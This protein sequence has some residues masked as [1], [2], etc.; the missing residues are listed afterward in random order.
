MRQ[1]NQRLLSILSAVLDGVL[2]LLSYCLAT[3]LWLD[4]LKSDAG[5]LA[6]LRGG[7]PRMLMYAAIY[8]VFVVLVMSLLGLYSTSRVRRLRREIPRIWGANLLGLLAGMAVLYLLRA[9]SFSRGVLVLFYLFSA[10]LLSIKCYG[11]R[12][13]LAEARKRGYNQRHVLVLGSGQLAAH[14]MQD[15]SDNPGLGLH[16]LGWL[17]R[18]DESRPG[19]LAP[20]QGLDALLQRKDVDEVVAALEPE[21]L[22]SIRSVINACEKSGTKVSVV[23]FYSDLIPQSAAIETVGST[24]IINLRANPLDNLGL[25]ML[26]RGF[27]VLASLLLLILLSPLLAVLAIGVKLSGPGPVLFRQERVGRNKHLFTMFKFR[28]MVPNDSENKAWSTAEDQR[29]TG[30]GAFMR[31]FSLDELP[32][33]LNVLRGDMSLVGPRPEIPFYVERFK[34][35]VPLYMVK[36]QVRPGMTGWAQVNGWRGDTDIA[37]RIRYD[38]WYIENWSIRLDLRIL[39]RTAFGGFVNRQE[40]SGKGAKA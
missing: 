34:E 13:A 12:S 36:H 23:P 4:V 35:S 14:Y 7:H 27:D 2:V 1:K 20:L 40:A 25:A 10:G 31:K 29:R 5:N 15:V 21:E 9:E 38:I 32:Q 6:G 37:T 18:Q 19:W 22:D 33:L 3:W 16:V 39:W 24:H 30:F 8:A 28:S 11:L 17:G 26:K